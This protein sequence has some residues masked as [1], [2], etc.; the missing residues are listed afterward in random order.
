MKATVTFHVEAERPHEWAEMYG[1]ELEAKAALIEFVR[2]RIED[3]FG[4]G[5]TG[6][7]VAFVWD[8][9]Q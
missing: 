9:D 6:L 3:R 4:G 2:D 8:E 1:G 7:M 5:C